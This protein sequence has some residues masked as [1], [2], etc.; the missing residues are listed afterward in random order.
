MPNLTILPSNGQQS[1]PIV[2][3]LEKD[4]QLITYKDKPIVTLRMVDELHQKDENATR[5]S[6]NNHREHFIEGEDFFK[7]PYSE[8]SKFLAVTNKDGSKVQHNEMIFLTESGYL[9]AIK[10]FTDDLSWKVQRELINNYFAYQKVK[11]QIEGITDF[12]SQS[13]K[14]TEPVPLFHEIPD[15]LIELAREA[16]DSPYIAALLKKVGIIP[17]KIMTVS[18]PIPENDPDY[19][20]SDYLSQCPE[21]LRATHVSEILGVSVQTIGDWVKNGKFDKYKEAGHPLRISKINLKRWGRCE[22]Y[23]ELSK[24]PPEI[25]QNEA[26]RFLIVCKRTILLAIRSGVIEASK[27]GAH[28][29]I[30]STSLVNM[31]KLSAN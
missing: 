16:K 22:R 19:S 12:V 27:N 20:H 17:E 26:A 3:I 23:D 24:L 4:V 28:Y 2:H 1:S 6:F 10:P 30:K 8:W 13:P 31:M 21:I 9:M 25:S 15:K 11:D 5:K 14:P 29:R 7:L 18:L